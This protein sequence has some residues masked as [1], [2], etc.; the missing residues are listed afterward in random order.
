MWAIQ[1]G[2][3]GPEI[4]R[5]SRGPGDPRC[6]GRR[7]MTRLWVVVLFFLLGAGVFAGGLAGVFYAFRGAV[8]GGAPDTGA[9]GLV[10]PGSAGQGGNPLALTSRD[11]AVRTAA[12]ENL[13]RI[14]FTTDGRKLQPQVYNLSQSLDPH[15]RLTDAL[16]KLL[17]GPLSEAYRP[18][19]P[20]GTRLRAAYIVG[21]LAVVDLGGEALARRLG[22]PMA[23]LL[24]VYGI[25]NTAVENVASVRRVRIL[26]DGQPASVLWD[27]VDVSQPLAANL[28]LVQ[29][30]PVGP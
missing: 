24:C 26:V 27:T 25:V 7:G 8:A 2:Y 1:R 6:R 3:L 17:E 18:V 28:S 10:P 22:G 21:D 13:L 5:H 12:R 23:E 29:Y 19:V 11:V 20:L 4:S 14:Y 15:A 16:G 9:L 30:D